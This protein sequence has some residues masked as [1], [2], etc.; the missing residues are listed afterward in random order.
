MKTN[1]SKIEIAK[2]LK[3]D[4][5]VIYREL[6]HNYDNRY[7]VCK[8]KLAQLKPEARLYSKPKELRQQV[9]LKIEILIY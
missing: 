1:K 2:L 6:K 5:S 3:L 9:K 7:G 8:S 4:K